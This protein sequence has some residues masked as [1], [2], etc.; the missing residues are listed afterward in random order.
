MAKHKVKALRDAVDRVH[1]DRKGA[2]M[3]EGNRREIAHQIDLALIDLHSFRNID[4]EQK[5]EQLSARLRGTS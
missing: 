2:P 1:A 3:E 4:A 5:L